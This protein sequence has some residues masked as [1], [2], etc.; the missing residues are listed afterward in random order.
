MTEEILEAFESD[1]ITFTVFGKQVEG[2]GSAP[3]VSL[4]SNVPLLNSNV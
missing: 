3:K 4:L 2:K 1:S